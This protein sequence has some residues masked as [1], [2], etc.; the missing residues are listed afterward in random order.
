LQR[1]ESWVMGLLALAL[2]YPY[3]NLWMAFIPFVLGLLFFLRGEGKAT[4]S[5]QATD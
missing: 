3:P 4:A 5:P 2:F 1:W